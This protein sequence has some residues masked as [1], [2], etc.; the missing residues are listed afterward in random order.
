MSDEDAV[1][2]VASRTAASCLALHARLLSRIL[3]DRYEAAVS[4]FGLSIVRFLLLGVVA[5]H[6]RVSPSKLAEELS[7]DPSTL[8]RNFK[9]L[10]AEGLIRMEHSTAGGYLEI[11]VTARGE[12]LYL[13][14]REGWV[15]AQRGAEAALGPQL[16]EAIK[17]AAR[18]VA[19]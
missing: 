16:S 6:G 13:K 9:A 19:D 15:A 4:P 3:T 2:D 12:E 8:S 7:F 11:S 17:D 18:K 10:R 1:R 14:A 5:A